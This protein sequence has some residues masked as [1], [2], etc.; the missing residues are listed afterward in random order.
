MMKREPVLHMVR[1]VLDCF[2]GAF[3]DESIQ[4][5][6]ENAVGVVRDW[7]TQEGRSLGN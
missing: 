5:C 4:E 1:S 7:W 2:Y 6:C 3:P